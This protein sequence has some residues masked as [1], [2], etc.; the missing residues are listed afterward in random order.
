MSMRFT[1]PKAHIINKEYPIFLPFPPFFFISAFV[2]SKIEFHQKS[3][4]FVMMQIVIRQ[5]FVFYDA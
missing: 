3:I 1:F 5:S 2:T 4:F